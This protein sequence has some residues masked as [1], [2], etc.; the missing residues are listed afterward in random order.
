MILQS[1]VMTA[2]KSGEI[3]KEVLPLRLSD[4]Y[5]SFRKRGELYDI[6]FERL[7]PYPVEKVWQAVTEPE[8]LALWFGG[9]AEVDL[10]VGGK[11]RLGLLMTTVEGVITRLEKE[12]LLEYTWGEDNTVR[13]E[14]Y[15]FNE[16]CCSLVF[17][18]TL[19]PGSYLPDAAPGWHGYL[20]FLEMVLA[21]DKVP[22]FPLEAWPEIAGEA[23]SKYKSI[24]EK[25]HR[26]NKTIIPKI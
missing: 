4:H 7:L 6:V 3:K 20:D 26:K 1:I 10:K 8:K 21:G 14:L 19:V 17:T 16:N 22:V 12:K 9:P 5:G 23:T 25:P 15:K 11:I 2:Q 13:W 18:E 24:I